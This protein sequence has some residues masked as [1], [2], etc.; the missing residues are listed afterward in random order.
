MVG[1]M[2]H[3]KLY[4]KLM[5]S[6]QWRVLR[7]QWLTDHPL[8]EEC[9]RQGYV[10]A[11]QCV[12]HITPVESGRTDA[13]CERL[14]FSA[15]NL[16]SLCYK[17]HADI[18]KAA[19]SHTKD[20]HKERTRQRLEQW[21]ARRRQGGGVFSSDPLRLPNPPL[22]SSADASNF[23]ISVFPTPHVKRSSE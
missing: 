17:C 12:H 16:Q 7:C 21:V 8:C 11:A 15:A 10:V 3:S 18:H 23:E 6:K 2:A 14:A 9:K 1:D 4:I 19:R 5:N 13:D 20:G 22:L